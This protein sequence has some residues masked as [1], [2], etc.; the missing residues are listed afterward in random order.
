MVDSGGYCISGARG[1]NF[2]KIYV[3]SEKNRSDLGLHIFPQKSKCSLKK[4]KKKKRSSLQFRLSFPYFR[5]KIKLFSKKWSSPRI[6]LSTNICSGLKTVSTTFEGGPPKKGGGLR[7]LPHSPHPI[8]TTD[9][10]T[11]T[12]MDVAFTALLPKTVLDLC[13]KGKVIK[14]KH[15]IN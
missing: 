12:E 13:S 6:T 1:K 8:S 9:G 7:Q 2:Q 4:K 11:L 14:S 15:T 3:A 5:P 10:R